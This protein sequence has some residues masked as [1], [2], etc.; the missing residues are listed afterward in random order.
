MPRPRYMK[1]YKNDAGVDIVLR[2]DVCLK[3]K[4]MTVIDLGCTANIPEGEAGFLLARTSAAK[5]GILIASCPVDADYSGSISAIVYNT[6]D[7]DII[8]KEGGSF[9]QLVVFKI[10]YDAIPAEVRKEGRRT[11]GKFGSTGLC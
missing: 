1:G 7:Y 6:N 2:E 11:D 4:S 5:K 9:C 8:Y 3:A 10:D